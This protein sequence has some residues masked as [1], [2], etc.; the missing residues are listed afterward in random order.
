MRWKAAIEKVLRDAGAPMHYAEIAQ[1]IIDNGY[2]TSV[3]ATPAATVAANL[4]STSLRDRVERIEKGV[5]SLRSPHTGPLPTEEAPPSGSPEDLDVDA[6][7]AD[8]DIEA[9]EPEM[10]LINA[11]GMFWRRSET[12]WGNRTPQLLG[13][14]Q[15]GSKP[16]D[17][18]D[19]A[20]VYLLYDGNRVI[21]VGRVTEPRLGQRL[22]EHTRGRLSGRWDRFSW[23]GVRRTNARGAL[24]PL[25]ST[26]IAVE[27]L[28]AT[29]EALLIEGLE[30]PQNRRQGDGFNAVEFIQVTDP[31]IERQRTQTVLAKALASMDQTQRLVDG[32]TP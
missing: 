1:A 14:Q 28:I 17:F 21:Y 23:F 24:G 30:P 6:P 29:M 2:R 4:S 19:Q 3:G 26:G 5:Y 25:P 12:D 32:T 9:V 20:G 7:L 10:G 22:R 27:T 31:A 13:I 16:V 8:S 11:F 15:S 18:T